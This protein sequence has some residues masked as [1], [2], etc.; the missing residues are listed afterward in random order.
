MK[1]FLSVIFLFFLFPPFLSAQK[2]AITFDDAP[3]R[4][5]QY[6]TGVQRTDTLIKKLREAGVTAA[7]FCTP[8]NARDETAMARLKLYNDAGH[9]IANHTFSHRRIESL[10]ANGYIEDIK[11]ADSVINGFSNFMR[12]FR[13]PFLDEGKTREARDS[14]RTGLRDMGYTNGYV[15]IDNYDWYINSLF[16]NALKEKQTVNYDK[17]R[18]LYIQHLIESIKFYDNIG[19]ET[20]GRSPAHILLLHENDIAALFIDEL[21]KEIRAQGYEIISPVEAYKDPIAEVIPDVLMN[22]QGRVSAIAKEKGYKGNL[23]QQSED[24]EYLDKLFERENVFG[25]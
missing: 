13:Y 23:G 3:I 17:L 6:Y 5:G 4:D 20:L 22:G 1:Y 11:M 14:V 15:T 10:D 19:R 24:E 12:W 16:M 21:V 18:E 25:K 9:I 7:F 2:I 8:G